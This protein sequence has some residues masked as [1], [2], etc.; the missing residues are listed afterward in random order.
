[1][2]VIQFT[3]K[4]AKLP[5]A[6]LPQPP[7]HQAAAVG[8][9]MGID[10]SGKAKC[11]FFI[12][13]GRIGKTTLA[14]YVSETVTA[15]GGEA[16]VAAVDP[17]NRSLRSFIDGVVEP[18]SA[19]PAEVKAWLQQLL[20]FIVENRH[21]ALIDLGGGD[22]S[23]IALLQDMPDLAGV[24]SAA[25]VE[26]VAIYMAGT[27]PHDLTPMAAA[28][29]AGFNPR[30]AA[31]VLNEAHG[32]RHS[33]DF[34]RVTDHPA[35]QQVIDRGAIQL[36]MPLLTPDAAR[37]IDANTWHYLTAKNHLGPFYASALHQWL[38]RMGEDIGEPIGT[39][40]PG[41]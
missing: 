2:S 28:E 41:R 5:T 29:A 17:V 36:W 15:G 19:D 25:G 8:G 3:P 6:P 38:R 1:M 40:F 23:L 20:E 16:L 31:I 7:A 24:M 30:A 13:R 14:R 18:P 21:S 9:T 33:D 11:W 39:W 32:R 10:L 12:G 27:D 35:F 37:V 22:T 26:P 4:R 34:D